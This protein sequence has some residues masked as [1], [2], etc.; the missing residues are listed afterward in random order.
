MFDLSPV[1]A[2]RG[3]FDH[4][5][6]TPCAPT[7][8]AL[9]QRASAHAFANPASPHRAGQ[10]A[11][12]Y[13]ERA[14][15][16]V[17]DAIGAL[18]S[19]IV[20]SSGAT[21]SNNLAILGVADAALATRRRRR[22]IVTLPVE[23][24]SV[25]APCEQLAKQNFEVAHAPVDNAGRVKLDALATLLDDDTLL[26][27]IQ[28]ANNELGTLQP[29]AQAAALAHERGVLVHCDAAQA[30]GKVR[31]D[32]EALDLDFAS[33]SAHKC[34]GPKGAGALW[35]RGGV[36]RAP[37]HARSFGG[38]HERG[39]RA[40][41]QNT[42]AIAGFGEAARIGATQLDEDAQ[43]IGAMRDRMEAQLR[44]RI[45][46]LRVNG[47]HAARLPGAS[48]LTIPGCDADALVAGL[49]EFALSTASACHAGTPEPSHVLR[50]IGL[51]HEDAYATLRIGLGRGSEEEDVARLVE[52]ITEVATRVR[53]LADGEA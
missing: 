38:G 12:F 2:A 19:E 36:A 39:L 35:V 53:A 15:E 44:A 16:Q 18:P 48:S 27:C 24:L 28:A 3:Y 34:Y 50:A 1:N 47:A 30:L 46:G 8:T 9:M 7:V 45:G 23:H 5:A 10:R 49:P 52:R 6:S 13:I 14:R 43:R 4:Q 17:A 37:I 26:L 11:A 25:L 20:F 51:T 40:G 29:L 33:L 32:V 42:V 31:F 22:R 41:T 21:E